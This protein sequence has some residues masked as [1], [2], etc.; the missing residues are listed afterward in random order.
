MIY[1]KSLGERTFDVANVL[2]LTVGS[3]VFLYPL[4][5]VIVSSF[6]SASAIAS[7]SVTLWPEGF[8]V[9][10]Y[11]RVFSDDN[12]WNA[13]GNT[14]FYVVVGTVVNLALTTLGAYPLSRRD[15]WGRNGVMMFIVFTMF[16]S[17]GLIPMYLNVRDLGLFDSRWAL[18]LPTAISAYNLIVMRTFFQSTIPD[19]LIESARME[20][21]SEYR[22]LW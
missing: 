16:F 17:G 11:S 8:N 15:L 10:A 14:L 3:F 9:D 1:K 13:Y 22:I 19:G 21:A 6:S 18:I 5:F 4:W 7:G 20:G 12:V 2:L